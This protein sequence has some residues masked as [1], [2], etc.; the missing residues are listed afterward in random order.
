MPT[1]YT[2]GLQARTSKAW[3]SLFAQAI[4]GAPAANAQGTMILTWLPVDDRSSDVYCAVPGD[5]RAPND[6]SCTGFVRFAVTVNSVPLHVAGV[7]LNWYDANYRSLQ[8]GE[9]RQWL[10]NYGPNQLVAGDFNAEPDDTALWAN[11]LTSRRD[12]WAQVT[13]AT[14]EPG[15]TK[16]KRSVTGKPGRID[17][18]FVPADPAHV[19][20]QQVG[21]VHTVLSDHHVLVADYII[22]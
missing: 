1:Y 11:W 19:G 21:V 13:A 15:F 16:D 22:Q 9:L 3:N 18:Q 10:S 6:S 17:Y 5:T 8:M 7:H 20:I 4:T 14:G 2:S 12:V